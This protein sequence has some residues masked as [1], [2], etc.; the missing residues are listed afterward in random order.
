MAE[1]YDGIERQ[2]FSDAYLFFLKYKDMR[3]EDYYWE[4]CIQDARILCFK[5]K[6]HQ[7]IR[8]LL[9]ATIN[10]L[11]H[12]VSGKLMN[13]LTHEQWEVEVPKEQRIA[14]K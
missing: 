9:S 2:M 5:Y 1:R 7:L 6:N 10:Q 8:D 13:G 3:N 11:E 14:F 12:K 4:C